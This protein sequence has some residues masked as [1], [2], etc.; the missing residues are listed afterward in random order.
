M[1]NREIDMNFYQPVIILDKT[2]AHQ[3]DFVFLN[4]LSFIYIVFVWGLWK[5]KCCLFVYYWEQFRGVE[6]QKST[7]MIERKLKRWISME[8]HEYCHNEG[9][10]YL[11]LILKITWLYRYVDII[12]FNMAITSKLLG[13]INSLV[14]EF[15]VMVRI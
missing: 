3:S 13:I 15:R 2:L 5:S 10:T 12:F 11:A 6:F 8:W 4:I 14:L 1:S 9:V 7:I